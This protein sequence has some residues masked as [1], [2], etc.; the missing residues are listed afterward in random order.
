MDKIITISGGF[1][2]I[3]TGIVYFPTIAGFTPTEFI[4]HKSL[5][6]ITGIA[7]DSEDLHIFGWWVLSH[8]SGPGYIEVDRSGSIDSRPQIDQ[9]GVTLSDDI[10]IF[11]RDFKMWV[12][13]ML[14][15][16]DDGMLTVIGQSLLFKSSNDK[17]LNIIFRHVPVFID[18]FTNLCK[19]LI[20]DSLYLFTRRDMTL[21]SVFIDNR[22]KLLDEIG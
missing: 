8:I 9:Y 4:L 6:R 3:P 19:C 20:F 11:R 18:G 22:L 1:Y 12:G 13:R 7:D 2:D 15:N 17:L 14:V 5:G 16:A 10:G 21:V